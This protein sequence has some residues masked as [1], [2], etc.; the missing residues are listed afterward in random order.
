MKRIY[1]PIAHKLSS[2]K[3]MLFVLLPAILMACSQNTKNSE[4]IAEEESGIADVSSELTEM[5]GARI[6][7]D[8]DTTL[9]KMDDTMLNLYQSDSIMAVITAMVSPESLDKA[10]EEMAKDVTNDDAKILERNEFRENDRTFLFQKR[11]VKQQGMKFIVEMY[12]VQTDTN[13]VIYISGFYPP[14]APP[15]YATSIRKAALSAQLE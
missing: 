10:R 2:M 4:I 3:R 12:I 15:A 11:S 5:L 8:I 7:M 9:F 1:L 13:Q 6:K 14:D